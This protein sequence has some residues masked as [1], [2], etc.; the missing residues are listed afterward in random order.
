MKKKKRNDVELRVRTHAR[1]ARMYAARIAN[2]LTHDMVSTAALLRAVRASRVL[3][4]GRRVATRSWKAVSPA[5]SFAPRRPFATKGVALPVQVRTHCVG[6]AV[7]RVACLL[8]VGTAANCAYASARMRWV[9]QAPPPL[10]TR[11]MRAVVASAPAVQDLRQ[12]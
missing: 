8:R 4:V 10:S 11:R 7:P 12:A 5:L 2:P 1:S 3:W 9:P 6:A